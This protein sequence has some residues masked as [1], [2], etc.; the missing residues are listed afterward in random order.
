MTIKQ[1]ILLMIETILFIRN[2]QHDETKY[3]EQLRE[4]VIN[5]KNPPNERLESI[6]IQY[7]PEY[8]HAIE[9]A[10]I[11]HFKI[12]KI[13]SIPEQKYFI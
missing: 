11:Y 13:G 9:T 2:F 5:A 7:E 12:E 10:E 4:W 8:Q 3:L 6:Q 1:E